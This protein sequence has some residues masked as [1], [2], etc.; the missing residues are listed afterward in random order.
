MPRTVGIWIALAVFVSG[1]LVAA[2]QQ[3]RRIYTNPEPEVKKLFPAAVAFSPLAGEP[4][5]FK[6]YGVD[7]KTNP[8]AP[9]IGY[10]FWTTDMVPNEHG[11]HGPIHLL[12]GLDLTGMHH[13]RH[14]RLPLRAVR[15]LLGRAAG[16]R[17]AVQGQEHLR[18]V[19]RRRRHRC[20]VARVAHHQQR[21]ARH[22]RQLADDGASVPRSRGSQ[23]AI[24]TKK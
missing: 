6:V 8:S 19:P 15:L 23:A 24:G 16:V 14:R 9:P 21:D 13:R 4:L 1:G 7:P 12:V 20:G 18:S 10:V 11:Y 5:H 17:G 2:A 3:R 22:P